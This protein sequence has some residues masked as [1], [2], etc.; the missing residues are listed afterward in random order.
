MGRFALRIYP[1]KFLPGA[2]KLSDG[3][4]N[5]DKRLFQLSVHQTQ[6]TFFNLVIIDLCVQFTQRIAVKRE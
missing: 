5:L 6:I 4:V 1:H 2:F 3:L